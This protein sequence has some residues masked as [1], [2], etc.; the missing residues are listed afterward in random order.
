MKA[1]IL[2]LEH[3]H[4][5]TIGV[6]FLDGKAICWTLELPY[7]GNRVNIS[8]IPEG[9]YECEKIE[10]PAHGEC[11]WV[12]D[13]PHRSDILLG[14]VGNSHND[15]E[16][17]IVLGTYPADIIPNQLRGIMQS[18]KAVKAFRD[19]TDEV[20]KLTLAIWSLKP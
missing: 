11:F 20:T 10:S 19:A 4:T 13:V 17:C 9:L 5:E 16:G 3:T 14:H 18:T 12:K 15:T 8:C 2:R 7:R 6:L 1:T